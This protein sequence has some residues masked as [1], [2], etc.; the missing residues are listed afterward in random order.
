[1]KSSGPIRPAR[2][3]K[4]S[5]KEGN[6]RG[7]I[8]PWAHNEYQAPHHGIPKIVLQPTWVPVFCRPLFLWPPLSPSQPNNPPAASSYLFTTPWPARVIYPMQ[9]GTPGSAD[10]RFFSCCMPT[11]MIRCFF[12]SLYLATCRPTNTHTHTQSKVADIDQ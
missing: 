6:R 5:T 12:L 4:E 8:V 3:T 2:R 9:C 10:V 11:P 1:M 7:G